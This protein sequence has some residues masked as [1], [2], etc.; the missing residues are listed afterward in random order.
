MSDSLVNKLLESFD[1]LERCIEMTKDVLAQKEG[2]P[3]DVLARV[4]QYSDI[5]AKQRTLAVDLRDHLSLQNWEEVGRHVRLING[6]ST[7]IRD[8]AQAILSG[9][10]ERTEVSEKNSF[11]L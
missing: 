4:N 1:E 10:Y 7:M 8:D 6:L 3:Q 2:V 11:L 5:V 9:A